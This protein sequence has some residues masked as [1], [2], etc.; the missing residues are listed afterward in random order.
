[1]RFRPYLLPISSAFCFSAIALF[2]GLAAGPGCQQRCTGSFD[3]QGHGYC[4]I[5]TGRCEVDCLTDRDCREPPECRD[6]PAACIPKGLFCTSDNRCSGPPQFLGENERRRPKGTPIPNRA[7]GASDRPGSGPAFVVNSL[8]IAGQGIGMNVDQRG[9][10]DGE[11]DNAM[12]KL[13]PLANAEISQGINSGQSLLLMELAGLDKDFRGTDESLTVNIYAGIDADEHFYAANNFE[14][15][16]NQT[17][18]CEFK[19]S[20][21][22]LY[23]NQQQGYEQARSIAPAAIQRNQL[24]S[25]ATVRVQFTLT[26]GQPPYHEVVLENMLLSGRVSTNLDRISYG[27]IGAA[28]PASSLARIPNP[29][30]KAGGPGCPGNLAGGNLLDLATWTLGKRPDIDL[31]YDGLECLVDSTG[32]SFVDLCCDGQ[33]QLDQSCEINSC[34][35]F[36]VAGSSPQNPGSCATNDAI[37]DGYSVGMRFSAVKA[38]LKG[39]SR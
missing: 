9:E 17:T 35:G 19:I 3:C 6:N 7:D 20:S 18:C 15:P 37:A 23:S 27:L 8:A 29:Y 25:F 31:D 26:V 34:P 14:V 21:S 11:I 39:L 12:W 24:R 2:A 22:S 4:E 13:G 16:P 30:C 1:M 36:E 32:D 10:G 33:G 28:I 38:Y 5:T